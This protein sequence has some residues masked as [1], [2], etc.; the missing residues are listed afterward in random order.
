MRPF[1]GRI[2]WN[3]EDPKNERHFPG[4]AAAAAAAAE[5]ATAAAAAA[6]AA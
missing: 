6:I 5:A 2:I 1:P 4:V 3:S